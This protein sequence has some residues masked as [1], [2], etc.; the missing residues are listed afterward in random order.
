[1]YIQLKATRN[2]KEIVHHCFTGCKACQTV[3]YQLGAFDNSVINDYKSTVQS[4]SCCQV[5]ILSLKQGIDGTFFLLV[6]KTEFE[7]WPLVQTNW[8]FA[9]NFHESLKSMVVIGCVFKQRKHLNVQINH[10]R[11]YNEVFF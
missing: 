1:M 6:W 5:F 9:F 10:S 2:G 3:I 8:L 4:T 11:D 7:L